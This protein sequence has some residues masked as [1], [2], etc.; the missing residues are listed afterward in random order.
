MG[1]PG[2]DGAMGVPGEDGLTPAVGVSVKFLGRHATGSFDEGAAEIVAYDA[3]TKRV[4]VV[5][6]LAASVDVL[7]IQNPTLPGG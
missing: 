7:D 1:E 5:N 2:M 4:F 3:E 6:A